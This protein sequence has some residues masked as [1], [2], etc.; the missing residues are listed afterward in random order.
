MNLPKAITDCIQAFERLPGIG[1]KT[2][3]RLSFYLLRSPQHEAEKLAR[4]LDLIHSGTSIC[5]I[6]HNVV[7]TSPCSICSSQDRD[8][9]TI[10]VVEEPL[11]VFA[12]ERVGEYRGTY[13]VLGGVISPLSNIGP[14]DL[15]IDSLLVRIRQGGV[16]E[17][18]LATNPSMEGEATA[19]YLTRIIQ[20]LGIKITRIGQGL[21][22][23]G[24][25]EYADDRTLR[26]ALEARKEYG[27]G[28]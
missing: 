5:E 15:F 6:C 16:S 10:C 7:D 27:E 13:H 18:I 12:F 22:T 28:H 23:G 3:Q 1:P 20:P 26:N 4:A 2:A 14:K 19:L 8:K 9:E 21:P 24:D 17:L 25:I 11:D